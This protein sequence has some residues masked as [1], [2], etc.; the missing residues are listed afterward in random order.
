MTVHPCLRLC[1]PASVFITCVDVTDRP[2]LMAAENAA[3]VVG[4]RV[5]QTASEVILSPSA[6]GSVEM[7]MPVGQSSAHTVESGPESVAV[8]FA[9]SVSAWSL[10][11]S[12]AGTSSLVETGDEAGQCNGGESPTPGTHNIRNRDKGEKE[13]TQLIIPQTI[14]YGWNPLAFPCANEMIEKA[15]HSGKLHEEL[16]DTV[17][18][19]LPQET[20]EFIQK[21]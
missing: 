12:L 1:I 8:S 16:M 20:P 9:S 21:L 14:L 18:F 19:C 5:T 4:A 15:F 11:A 17:A 2:K 3:K 6:V 7:R 13:I 10:P